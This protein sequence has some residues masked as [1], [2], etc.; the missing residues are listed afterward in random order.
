MLRI[1]PS[2]ASDSTISILLCQVKRPKILI[3]HPWS[4]T[5]AQKKILVNPPYGGCRPARTPLAGGLG[6]GV[7]KIP[8][9]YANFAV[10]DF[11]QSIARSA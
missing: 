10:H 3:D 4:K 6:R 5:L 8:K 7:Y 11:L 2:T 1:M 9:L